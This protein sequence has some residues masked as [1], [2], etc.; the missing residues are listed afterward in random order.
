M[1]HI[2]E[3]LKE[4]RIPAGAVED[5]TIRKELNALIDSNFGVKKAIQA[6]MNYQV[7]LDIA[8]IEN[9]GKDVAAAK[10][11]VIKALKQKPYIIAAFATDAC[12]G[13][14]HHCKRRRCAGRFCIGNAT[15]MR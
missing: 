12:T 9:A 15:G 6:V 11:L 7:Y 14:K 4:N 1:A 8:A 10:Q 3:F 5:S 13:A 2:P